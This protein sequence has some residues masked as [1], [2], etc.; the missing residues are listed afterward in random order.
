MKEIYNLPEI[1]RTLRERREW[2]QKQV[3][4]KIGIKYQ[5]YQAYE[6]GITL[7]TLTNYIKLADLYE[8]PMDALIDRGP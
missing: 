8:L 5:S 4:E 6:L 1:L 2:T 3:A 7:P